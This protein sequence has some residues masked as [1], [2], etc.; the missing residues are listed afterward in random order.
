MTIPNRL[1]T[2]LLSMSLCSA[3]IAQTPHSVTL[4]WTW[5]EGDGPAATGF[6]VKRGTTAGGPYTTIA[7][8]TVS[9]IRTY[10]D[11]SG[12]GDIL[13]PG[14]T[15]YYVVTALSG[16]AES[17]PSPE[18]QATIP[19]VVSGAPSSTFISDLANAASLTQEFAPGM[20]LRVSG[21]Q[22][23]SSTVSASHVPLP[24]LMG[25]VRA[26]V[27]GIAVPLYYVSPDE[28]R[29]QIP[30]ETAAGGTATLL[31]E[32][33]GQATSQD[34]I[35]ASAAPGIFTDGTGAIVPDGSAIRGR[36]AAVF[37]TGT[38][39]LDPPVPTG[40]APAPGT[41][42]ADLPRPVQATTVTVGGVNA[43][44][45]FIGV[46]A[47]MVGV[48]QINFQVPDG[49]GLGPQPVIVTVG[50][51]SSAPATLNVTN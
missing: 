10:T 34:F 3:L 13:T 49:V 33:N 5:S 45:E 7:T 48:T 11:T 21:S 42:V 1:V 9:R 15:Y 27:G 8:L 12:T 47:G 17:S 18:A 43:P 39:S 25:G 4:N 31:I 28:L 6:N 41:P 46:P 19:A 51:F 32:N 26:F 16:T 36:S 2:A 14:T 29:I 20:I 22:L 50:T 23:A 44:V 40:S 37:V 35:V 24:V 38:G 30:Y